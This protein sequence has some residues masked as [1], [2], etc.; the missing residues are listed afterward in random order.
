MRLSSQENL[1]NNTE[2]GLSFENKTFEAGEFSICAWLRG[3]GSVL[4]SALKEEADSADEGSRD[5]QVLEAEQKP[6]MI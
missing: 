3:S 4:G 5:I 2:S 6:L 1:G